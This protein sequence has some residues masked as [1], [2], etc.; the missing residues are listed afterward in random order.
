MQGVEFNTVTGFGQ[1]LRTGLQ[2]EP[3]PPMPAQRV[4]ARGRAGAE[5]R[6]LHVVC[7]LLGLVQ[8]LIDAGVGRWRIAFAAQPHRLGQRQAGRRLETGKA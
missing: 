7:G 5:A 4:D 3:R 2:R 1:A 8:R 6:V